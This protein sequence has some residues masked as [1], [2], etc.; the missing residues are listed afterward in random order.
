MVL[1]LLLVVLAILGGYF[2]ANAI[3]KHADA[4]YDAFEEAYMEHQRQLEAGN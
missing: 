2:T 1:A 3:M 4:Q